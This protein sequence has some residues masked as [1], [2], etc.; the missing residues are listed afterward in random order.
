[1]VTHQ[2]IGIKKKTMVV[3]YTCVISGVDILRKT[4]KL[5]HSKRVQ[6]I[7]N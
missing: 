4:I 1:M 6:H 3:Q 2:S 5:L 7:K